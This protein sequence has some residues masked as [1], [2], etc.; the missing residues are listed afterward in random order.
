ML[1]VA[2]NQNVHILGLP[3][4]ALPIRSIF[5][6]E[7][8]TSRKVARF[9]ESPVYLTHEKSWQRSTAGILI[10]PLH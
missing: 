10:Q 1:H 7:K 3:F 8:E 4:L 5:Q 6:S 2:S 9:P